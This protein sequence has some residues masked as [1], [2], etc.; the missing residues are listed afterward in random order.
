MADVPTP[1]GYV[2]RIAPKSQAEAISSKAHDRV[3]TIAKG[4]LESYIHSFMDQEGGN[5]SLVGVV[6]PQVLNFV[7]DKS[8]KD[9]GDPRIRA[10]QLTRLYNEVREKLPAVLIVDSSY[11]WIPNSLGSIAGGRIVH[12]TENV[13]WLIEQYHITAQVGVIVSI[14]TKDQDTTDMLATFLSLIFGP[15]R[16]RC[17]GSRMRSGEVGDNWEVRIPLEFTP[18]VTQGQFITED[19]KDQIWT[20]QIELP[21]DFEDS[22]HFRQRFLTWDADDSRGGQHP[23]PRTSADIPPVITIPDTIQ[24]NSP[25]PFVVDKF[26]ISHKIVLDSPHIATLD[27]EQCVITPRRL[28]TF[29]LQIVDTLRPQ[30]PG[31]MGAGEVVAEKTITV[32]L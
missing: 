17:G 20:T 24:I 16:N 13:P 7:T 19:R 3:K 2:K 31:T 15:L 5:R 12:D 8:I 11:R 21:L 9:D 25:A 23:G 1:S 10:T 18:S 26:R 27:A 14:A 30:G 29:K 6:S 28:G 22:F 4:A 32:V